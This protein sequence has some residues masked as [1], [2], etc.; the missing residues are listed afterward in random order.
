[1]LHQAHRVAD[2][3]RGHGRRASGSRSTAPTGGGRALSVRHARDRH[4][5]VSRRRGE[6]GLRAHAGRD[7]HV[8]GADGP[9]DRAGGRLPAGAGDALHCRRRASAR[10]GPPSPMPIRSTRCWTAGMRIPARASWTRCGRPSR[11]A[12]GRRAWKHR[13]R[14]AGG[15]GARQQLGRRRAGRIWRAARRPRSRSR[16]RLVRLARGARPARHADARL[17]AGHAAACKAHDF[18]EGVRAVLIDRDQAPKWQP[19]R[20][21][22]VSEATIDAY[23]APLGATS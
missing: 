6:L 2:R 1:M 5:P 3:W 14:P 12:S 18:Y 10:S 13:W 21:E 15:D 19:D 7:R 16:Y 17:P 4:R 20:L 8:P 22:D 11:A 23:F 9:R